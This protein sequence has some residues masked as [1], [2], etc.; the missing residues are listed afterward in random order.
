M[1]LLNK[2]LQNSSIMNHEL[3]AKKN[4]A[5]GEIGYGIMW[6]FVAVMVEGLSLLGN[7]NLF[8]FH[9]ISIPAV[10]ASMYKFYTGVKK[11]SKINN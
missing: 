9:F 2:Y 1:E 4:K 5:V 8:V 10:M 11:Y 6:L 7:F 3:K